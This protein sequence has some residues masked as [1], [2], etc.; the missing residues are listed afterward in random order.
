MYTH[1][2]LA[3]CVLE[4]VNA[5]KRVRVHGGHDPSGILKKVNG[6]SLRFLKSITQR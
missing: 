1:R 3:L 5:V 6:V 2:S 4:D